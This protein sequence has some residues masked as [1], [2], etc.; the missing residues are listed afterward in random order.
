MPC[1]ALSTG[2]ALNCK[3][4]MGGL[5]AVYFFDYGTADTLQI[6]A[7]VVTGW[8]GTPALFQYD[9]KGVSN[10]E[11]T[12]NASRDNGTVFYEQTLNLTLPKLDVET[13]EELIKIINARPQCI[14][15]DYNKNYLLIGA[16]NGTDCS[17]GTIVTGSAGG[18]LT[19]FTITQVGM[20]RLPAFFVEE[21]VVEA[22]ISASA[23]NPTQI[24]PTNTVNP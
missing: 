3:D 22:S 15:E 1:E 16:E 19:G 13:Q 10:L 6:T 4:S 7:G 14:V 12:V 23:S 18:D 11:Q 24:D 5:K 2:R 20:E 9:L 21:S 17:G 8:T